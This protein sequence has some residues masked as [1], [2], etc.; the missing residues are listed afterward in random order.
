VTRALDN[1]PGSWPDFIGIGATTSDTTWLHACI[2]KHTD[3]YAPGT[4]EPEFFSTRYELRSLPAPFSLPFHK[5]APSS[6]PGL[7]Q[8]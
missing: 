5:N 2:A 4:K 6:M 1:P 7:L 3:V 8:Y